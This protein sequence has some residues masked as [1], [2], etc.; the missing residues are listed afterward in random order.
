MRGWR[1]AIL[2]HSYLDLVL[3]LAGSSWVYNTGEAHID[4][5]GSEN[6]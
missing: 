1:S 6:T 5:G 3:V 2:L 4:T